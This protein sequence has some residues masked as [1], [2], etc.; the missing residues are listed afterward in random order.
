M[1]TFSVGVSSM[2]GST[3]IEAMILCRPSGKT[4]Q[5]TFC[6]PDTFPIDAQW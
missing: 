3:T 4:Y 2:H 6:M 5:T 1:I